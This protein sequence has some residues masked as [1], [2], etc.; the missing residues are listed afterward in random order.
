MVHAELERC[1]SLPAISTLQLAST[2][3]A[4]MASASTP[5]L[6]ATPVKEG[7]LRRWFSHHDE[8]HHRK[9]SDG[10]LSRVMS[11]INK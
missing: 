7:K 6:A 5:M 11:F 8:R 1:R 9:E 3:I 10:L 4:T 2:P